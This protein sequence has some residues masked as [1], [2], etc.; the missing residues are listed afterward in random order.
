MTQL[1]GLR[2]ALPKFEAAGMRLYA[3]SYDDVESLADFSRHHDIG[4]PLLFG[5]LVCGW[6]SGLTAMVVVRLLWRLHVVRR[7]KERRKHR[8]E[9]AV[10]RAANPDADPQG[11]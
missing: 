3:V 5:S 11:G 9:R 4:Y 8:Q 10:R 6:V 2:D 1:V 7:W